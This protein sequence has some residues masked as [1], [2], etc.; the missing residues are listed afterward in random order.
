M[1]KWTPV[2]KAKVQE[3]ECALKQLAEEYLI[4]SL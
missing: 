1:K 2:D 3:I 4:S